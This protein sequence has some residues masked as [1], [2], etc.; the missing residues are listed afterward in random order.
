M[1]APGT[2]VPWR[3]T[4]AATALLLVAGVLA[5]L[6]P[7]TARADSAPPV[8]S[9]TP[10][11]VAADALPTVQINGVAWQQVVVG[12]TVYVAG[13]FTSARPAG[14]AAGTSETPR[15][16]ILAYDI[17][18]GNLITSFAPTLN[19]QALTIAASPDGSRIY[20]GGDFTQANGQAR[21][22]VA[23]FDATTGALVTSWH[24]TVNSQVRA[25]AATA[26]TVYLGGS[27]TAVGG[28]SR[29]RLAAVRASDGGLLPWAPVPGVGSTA[30]NRD[31]NTATSDQVLGLVVT[32]GGTQVVA[33]GRFD[34]LNGV[35]AT[36]IGALD[37]TTG[38]TRPFAVNQLITNQGV[39]SAIYSLT[40]DGTTVYGTGYDY[41]GPGNVEG[42]FAA[43]ADGGALVEINDCRGD[44]YSSYAT[45][46]VLYVASHTHQCGF[47]GGFPEQ[48]PRVNRH[49]SAYT[50]TPATVVRWGTNV[51][52]VG[53][54]AGTQL[55]FFPEFAIGSYTGQSQAT[56][57]VTGN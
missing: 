26:D 39:N 14:A 16:N 51:N 33:S 48:T 21:Q 11:T 42:S 6:G 22:R 54:P 34:S 13:S 29:S 18:T 47:I 55:D 43:V 8:T 1:S 19:A 41:F 2:C 44:T 24:P 4:A 31:G 28:V 35:K 45:R 10:A 7:R 32:S 46:G 20:V 30:G 56:W 53:K 12:T 38:A 27:I 3:R 50:A 57:N 40:T 5:L 37:A 23:A 36:G 9:G 25:I 49:G 15:S 52:W 17:T